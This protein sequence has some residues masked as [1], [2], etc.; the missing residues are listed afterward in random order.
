MYDV[1][2]GIKVIE[3]A[4]H[5]FV[6]L[7]GMV[8]ADWGADVIKV[9]RAQGGDASRHI[10][11]P[12]TDGSVNPYFEVGNRGKR[13]IALDLTQPEGREQLYRLLETADVFL[14]NMRT[15]A[16]CK[17][18]IEAETLMERFPRLIYA[19]GTAYGLRGELADAGGFDYPS[20]WCRT[21]AAH[22]QT[23]SGEAP[24]WQPGSIGDMTGGMTLAGAI[25]AALF[26]RERT[27]CGAVVDNALLMM[28][29]FLMSQSLLAVGI[30]AQ[31]MAARPQETP[32]LPLANNF[33]TRDGRWLCLCVLFDA[34]W[35]DLVAHLESPELLDDVRFADGAGR[36]ANRDALT[37]EL[38]RIFAR[39]DLEDWSNR[40]ATL[41]GVWSPVKTPEEALIDPQSLV[42][43]FIS[44][45]N[46]DN[47]ITYQAAVSPAQFDQRPI[48]EL[49]AGPRFGQHTDEVLREL[50]LDDAQLA[51]LRGCSAIR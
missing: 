50:G 22:L 29:T 34:W 5:T 37:A 19:R 10:K 26:R 40:L 25:A 48:G 44:T 14:T 51:E 35:P 8:M 2:K 21:G 12:G 42:N 6:P 20:A 49:R 36:H 46:G 31:P 24:P 9:E 18:G 43:G 3:V 30:G 28:G 11:L 39:R 32:T 38:N 4:E 23:H 33:R 27:G 7:A 1:M 47:G 15:D 16:R 41:K 17:L 13:S 45:V